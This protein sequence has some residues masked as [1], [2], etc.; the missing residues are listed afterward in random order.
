M[1]EKIIPRNRYNVIPD[2]LD[3][4]GNQQLNLV[5]QVGC[6]VRDIEKTMA[7]FERILG[8]KPETYSTT[9]CTEAYYRGKPADYK[10]KIA[11]YSF[12]NVE[13]ELIQPVDGES[14]WAD[15][16]KENQTILH[17]IR[18]NVIDFDSVVK[19][20][21]DKGV[22]IYQNGKVSLDPRFRWAYFDTLPSLGFVLEV[23]GLA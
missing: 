17:H 23:L 11:F 5:M 15:H 10:I 3:G 16:L 22:E 12:A 2:V 9:G 4:K 7:E 18:F 14:I 1:E 20:M 13:F 21:A 6:V 19:D 8:V